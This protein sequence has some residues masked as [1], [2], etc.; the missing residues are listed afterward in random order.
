[1]SIVY[2][3]ALYTM[4]CEAS[5]GSGDGAALQQALDTRA[6]VCVCVYITLY[7]RKSMVLNIK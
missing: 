6:R 5:G 2:V 7:V 1:M 3:D 4:W